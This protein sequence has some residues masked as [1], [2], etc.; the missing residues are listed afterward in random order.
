MT[1]GFHVSLRP[2]FFP[3]RDLATLSVV[4]SVIL[5]GDGLITLLM[6]SQ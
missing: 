4:A 6:P 5:A 3:Q 2:E 1:E